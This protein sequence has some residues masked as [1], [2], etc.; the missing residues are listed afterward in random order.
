MM[1]LLCKLLSDNF[2]KRGSTS[3]TMTGF[4][5]LINVAHGLMVLFVR[6]L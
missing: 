1:A 2:D 3:R 4:K 5:R 6:F